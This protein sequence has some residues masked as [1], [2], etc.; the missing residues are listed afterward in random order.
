M[1]IDLGAA[2]GGGAQGWEILDA[3][4]TELDPPFAVLDLDALARNAEELR[5]RAGRLPIRVASKSLRSRP[6]LEA[7][8]AQDGFHGILAYALPE[9]LWL[10]GH[11]IRDVV[12]G[13]PSAHRA[14]IAALAADEALA[15]QVT[16][17]VD[18]V[19]Q[20]DLVD[21]V[22]APGARAEIR[23]AIELDA[24]WDSPLVG[25]I[26]VRRSPIRTP[27][28]LA[29][30]AREIVARPGFRLVGIMA[31]EAQ[32]AGVQDAR[33]GHPIDGLVKRWMQRQSSAELAERRSASV[34]A[35]RAVAELEFVNGGGTGSLESTSADSSVTEAA[36]GSG[37]FGPVLFDGYSRFTPEPAVAFALSVVRRPAPDI[38]TVAGGGWIASGPAGQDRVPTPV[39]PEGL[40]YVAREGAGEVQ[41]PLSGAAARDLRPGDRVWFRHAKSGEVA[42]HVNELVVVSGGAIIDRVP[43]YRGEG[44]AWL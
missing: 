9:A 37:L 30:L 23:V 25:Y 12:V 1:G 6:V 39:W 22:A 26:G 13:Y 8:L 11:G 41:S 42:E 34:A 15:A 10:A 33:R 4:T 16:I 36:A 29:A 19:E 27:E 3:A 21:A 5:R 14:A 40:D 24:S 32:I 35:V 38:A 31:Y 7:V 17:M 18:S 2:Q 43:T 28:R 20:L 44:K